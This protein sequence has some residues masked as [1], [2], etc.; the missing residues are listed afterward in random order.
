MGSQEEVVG[1]VASRKVEWVWNL[2][3]GQY[4]PMRREVM[5]DQWQRF[6][7][8]QALT[9]LQLSNCPLIPTMIWK[10]A[11][12]NIQIV[13]PKINWKDVA[14]TPNIQNQLSIKG[15]LIV[16]ADDHTILSQFKNSSLNEVV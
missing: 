11:G 10:L 7:G 8:Q 16:W 6:Y 9:N 1:L 4:G 13:H 14:S 12:N 3:W 2:P 5:E 15:L